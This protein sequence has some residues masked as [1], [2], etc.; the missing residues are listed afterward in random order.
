MLIPLWVALAA[1]AGAT[2]IPAALSAQA[3]G[4]A[5]EVAACEKR[6][7]G[8]E[9]IV[10]LGGTGN[11]VD[12]AFQQLPS[13]DRDSEA[14]RALRAKLDSAQWTL[15]RVSAKAGQST[16]WSADMQLQ[17]LEARL[18]KLSALAPSAD[19]T[20]QALDLDR[21][22][23][24]LV[25]GDMKRLSNAAD[26]QQSWYRRGAPGS[27]QQAALEESYA[28]R[29]STL[30]DKLR[31][32][33]VAAVPGDRGEAVTEADFNR[34]KLTP[35]DLLRF[36]FS[37][38]AQAS[39]IRGSE[40]FAEAAKKTG[41][42][43]YKPRP[44]DEAAIPPPPPGSPDVIGDPESWKRFH[45][46]QQSPTTC[47]VAAQQQ[48]LERRG[49]V[50]GGTPAARAAVEK[51]LAA[52]VEQAGAYFSQGSYGGTPP[53]YMGQLLKAR[54]LLTSRRLGAGPD[55]LRAGF[56]KKYDLLVDVDSGVL[57]DDAGARGT[58][59]VILVTG[60]RLDSQKKVSCYFVNDSAFAG[61]AGDCVPA[62]RFLAAWSARDR[63][64]LEVH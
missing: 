38:D 18:A 27:A 2:G 4:W 48:V 50:A 61:G 54:G 37:H 34:G 23:E 42:Q 60:A 21:E 49:L 6:P 15:I 24:R 1:S 7:C 8:S 12:H 35:R 22:A 26:V 10:R 63:Q 19:R 28:E 57:R 29:L 47:A 59:H 62:E 3:D 40:A 51:R 44:L 41:V 14:G 9:A 13:D 31:G 64:L 20:L 58:G 5:G 30:R 56:E 53:E 32:L 52:E 16:G 55:D 43:I 33:G 39:L 45:T 36:R 46:V 17:A 25:N 11:V